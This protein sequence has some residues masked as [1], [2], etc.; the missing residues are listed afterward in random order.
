MSNGDV[1]GEEKTGHTL[2]M[3]CGIKI[4]YISKLSISISFRSFFNS[5]SSSFVRVTPLPIF[6]CVSSQSLISAFAFLSFQD[7]R[8]SSFFQPLEVYKSK[9]LSVTTL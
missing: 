9:L 6:S 2:C 7:I 4:N 1:R 3:P 8:L 5:F